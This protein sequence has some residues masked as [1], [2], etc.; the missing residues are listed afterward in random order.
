MGID[1]KEAMELINNCLLFIDNNQFSGMWCKSDFL[2]MKGDLILLQ[3]NNNKINNNNSINKINNSNNINKINNDIY[4]YQDEAKS[5]FDQSIKIASENDMN[6]S[7]LKVCF[8]INFF[9]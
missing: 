3:Y 7:L 9:I 4:N 8:F 6:S 1:N 2:R 5:L